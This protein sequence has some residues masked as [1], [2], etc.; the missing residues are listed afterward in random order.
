MKEAANPVRVLHCIASLGGGGAERQLSY[1][2]SYF[3][4]SGA[5]V[6]IAYLNDGPNLQRLQAAGVHLHR[7]NA[8]HTFDWH[9]VTNLW[10]LVRTIR[11]QVIQTWLLH[12]DVVGGMVAML[13]GIPHV[14]SERSAE[15]FNERSWRRMVRRWVGRRAAAVVA[16]SGGGLEYWRHNAPLAL[17]RVIPNA[18]PLD[19]LSAIA[20]AS[21]AREPVV[22]SAGRLVPEKNVLG[23][24][25]GMALVARERRELR[26]RIFGDGPERAAACALRD[27]LGMRERIEILSYTPHLW[28][29]MSRATLFVSASLLEGAPN[30]VLEAAA[31]GCPLVLSDIPAHRELFDSE[32]AWFFSNNGP[33]HIAAALE[34]ALKDPATARIRAGRAR[35]AV[36]GRSIPAVCAE[37]EQVYRRVTCDSTIDGE[38]WHKS[39]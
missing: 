7:L 29:E 10:R 4:R 2:A 27:E 18:L 19:E 5:Q 17:K 26:F 16:N 6:H 34:M 12:M 1:L 33:E 35:D 37:Y 36:A 15:R 21:D 13:T 39:C 9:I 24:V 30:S 3:A 32:A 38:P 28:L 20:A 25:R 22:L 23:L 31:L 11:P 8:R 14:L